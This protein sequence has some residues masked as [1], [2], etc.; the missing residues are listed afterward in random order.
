MEMFFCRMRKLKSDSG[1]IVSFFGYNWVLIWDY[2]YEFGGGI[3]FS[4][5]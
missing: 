2:S 1:N 5:I 3:F 4:Y